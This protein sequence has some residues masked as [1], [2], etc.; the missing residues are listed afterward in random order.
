MLAAAGSLVAL[1]S[2]WMPWYVFRVPAAVLDAVNAESGRLGAFGSVLAQATVLARRLGPVHLT[3]WQV[4]GHA[5]VILVL[6]VVAAGA[7]A[8]LAVVGRA[9]G[10]GR[11]IAACA[12]VALLLA[13]YRTA[14]PP[15]PST[16]LHATW[17]AYVALAGST[18]ALVAGL[19]ANA[20]ESRPLS[21]LDGAWPPTVSAAHPAASPAWSP[22]D[23]FAPPGL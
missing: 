17:G 16:L 11:V 5:N 14:V 8:L 12:G 1:L 20:E 2:L 13:A 4:L 15:G 6:G 19:V 7:L 23:S 10:V 22:P 3:A 18:L 9:R 21:V